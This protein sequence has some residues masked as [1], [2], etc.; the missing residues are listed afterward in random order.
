MSKQIPCVNIPMFVS[1]ENTIERPICI[2]P[3]PM[4]DTW[5]ENKILFYK[6]SGRSN[7]R[8]EE[9]GETWFPFYGIM[10]DNNRV[11]FEKYDMK[12]ERVDPVSGAAETDEYPN[13]YFI[14]LSITHQI[15]NKIAKETNNNSS[16]YK[17]KTYYVK[18]VNE[19]IKRFV[20]SLH[21]ENDFKEFDNGFIIRLNDYFTE[22]NQIVLS[23]WLNE[24]ANLWKSRPRFVNFVKQQPYYKLLSD[25]QLCSYKVSK[26]N[27]NDDDALFTFF[28]ENGFPPNYPIDNVKKVLGNSDYFIDQNES[29]KYKQ[30]AV[31][32]TRTKT[33]VMNLKLSTKRTISNSKQDIQDI[34]NKKKKGGWKKTKKTKKRRALLT[35]TTG[36]SP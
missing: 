35:T 34:Q 32:K 20:D 31:M 13:G 17:Y 23:V 4:S 1:I 30:A 10:N 33:A 26:S 21:E 6:S 8:Q 12:K 18:E 5:T 9:T 7:D 27:N 36:I 25:R 24:K 2:L 28:T 3:Y 22:I 11:F 15:K 14:K 29:I 16:T 19:F